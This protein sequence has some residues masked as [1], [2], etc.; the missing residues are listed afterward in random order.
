MSKFLTFQKLFKKN[1]SAKTDTYH[2]VSKST[3]YSL[4]YIRWYGSWRQYCFYPANETVFDRKCLQDIIIF[5]QE[6]MD[7]R[8]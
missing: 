5:I 2:V 7:K 3:Q 6:L 4:G 8:K 1:K